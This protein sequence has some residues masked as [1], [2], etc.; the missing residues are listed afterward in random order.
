MQGDFAHKRILITGITGFVGSH[1]A[2]KLNS[3]GAQV[4]GISKTTSGK[5]ILKANIINHSFIDGFIKDTK[6]A[7]CFHL[8]GESLVESGQK[9]PYHT[10]KINTLGTL[11]ILEIARKRKLER[12]I[13]ASTAHVYGNNKLPYLETYT[14]KPTRPYE[15]SKT[16]TDLIVQSYADTF[17]L[18]ILISRFVNIY[19][20]GDLHFDRIIPK[21]M[22]T[23]LQNK[24]PVMWGRGIRRDYL[25][26]DDAI[27]AYIK[28]LHV[29]VGKI[30]GNRIFN[31][32]SGNI[33]TARELMEKIIDISGKKLSIQ[34]TDQKR[35]FEI[36][37]QY[38]SFGKA[39][40]MLK[41]KPRV[42]LDEGL[43]KTFSWYSKY[44]TA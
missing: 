33:V 27:D 3:L 22:R 11:N 20:P 37:A 28:L 18:P 24:R 43:K 16:C 42:D 32:G 6:I 39:T 21:T 23:V 17:Q 30:S 34:Q 38:V 25:Y 15:T 14:P 5:N 35:T 36:S 40:K 44:F 1:L 4:F 9:N 12:L 2:K 8:A 13:I 19:G 41:W 10:Y 29:D 26:I 7:V 31:F